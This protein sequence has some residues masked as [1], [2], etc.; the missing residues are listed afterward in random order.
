MNRFFSLIKLSVL[1]KLFIFI[2]L[3]MGL[4]LTAGKLYQRWDDDPNRGAIAIEQGHFDESYTTPLYLDQGWD[5]ADSLWFYNTT[6]GS[7]LLPYDFFIAL[8]QPDS[9]EPFLSTQLIDQYRYLPQ[10][11]TF[12]NPDGLPVGFVKETYQGKDYIGY[13]CAACHTGQ[14]NYKGHALRIDGGPAMADM[15]GFLKKLQDSLTA[16][17]NNN[18]KHQRFVAKV[19]ERDNSYSNPEDV[20]EDLVKWSRKIELYN[21]INHSSV[22]YGY[23]RLDAFGRI[24]NR[25]LEHVI[26]RAQLEE[27]LTHAGRSAQDQTLMLTQAQVDKVLENINET[28]IGDMQLAIIVD[29]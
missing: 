20:Q 16:A 25:V 2:A 28:I 4:I 24:Y 18:E 19:L 27:L 15:V 13:T 23:G 7:A 6:Q 11:P 1:I 12:L 10:K 17:K 22:E 3:V 8:E 5:E 26:S 29:R 21:A 9:K 14:V